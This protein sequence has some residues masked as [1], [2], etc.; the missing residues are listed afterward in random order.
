M[1]SMRVREIGGPEVMR[2]EEVADPEPGPKEAVI[3]VEAVGV[4][5]IDIYQRSGMYPM[6][7]PFTPGS[8][9][10]GRVLAVGSEV[11]ELAPGDTVAYCMVVGAYAGQAVIPAQRL[12]KLPEGMEA[13]TG[14]AAMLQGM[15]AH[16]LVHTTYP[17]KA[18]ETI[19]VHAGAGGVGLLLIQM[20]KRLGARVLTTVSTAEKAK[21]AEEAGADLVIRYTEEDFEERVK[22]ATQGQ[23][24]PVVYDSVGQTTFDMSMRCLMP[25][26]YMVLYGQSSGFVE[27][28]APNDLARGS[29]FLTRPGLV[30]ALLLSLLLFLLLV[31]PLRLG[32][33]AVEDPATVL[34]PADLVLRGQVPVGG[35]RGGHGLPE[36]FAGVNPQ[37]GPQALAVVFLRSRKERELGRLP[38]PGGVR[39]AQFSGE[40]NPRRRRLSREGIVK[41]TALPFLSS[42][43]DDDALRGGI[44]REALHVGDLCFVS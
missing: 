19:L 18:G 33:H 6:E 37:A 27:P 39:E 35:P 43:H 25:R 17:L 12:V 3:G 14:A 8:E 31:V 20:A 23:G 34:R 28:K 42:N 5:F 36:G 16:Y 40:K 1:K 9:A 22:E 30:V 13:R 26:G 24:V 7:L 4:N 11:T 15:T 2:Y 41:Q 44:E 32:L 21:L 29:F 38:A 10:S